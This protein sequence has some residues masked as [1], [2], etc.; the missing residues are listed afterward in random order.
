MG[1]VCVHI[2]LSFKIILSGKKPVTT[3]KKVRAR[4]SEMAAI[5]ATVTPEV[6]TYRQAD[7]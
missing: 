7:R 2:E 3:T 5:L 6:E 1:H 4:R